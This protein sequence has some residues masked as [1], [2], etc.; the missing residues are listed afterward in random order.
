[1]ATT[2]YWEYGWTPGRRRLF[3]VRFGAMELFGFSDVVVVLARNESEARRRGLKEARHI[4]CS[5]GGRKCF[6]A[7]VFDVR[8]VD[9][10]LVRQ[11]NYNISILV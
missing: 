3:L 1:M 8:A 5:V 6:D 10:G 11:A 9:A 7:R 4:L 2:K